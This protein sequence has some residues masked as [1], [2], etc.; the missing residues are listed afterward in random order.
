MKAYINNKTLSGTIAVP[1]SK[2]HTIRALIIATLAGGSSVIKNPL[3]SDD[4]RAALKAVELFG[5]KC[6]A[7][8]DEWIVEAPAGGLKT[9][10]DVVNVDN[11]GTTLYF[12]TSVASLLSDWVV[13]TGDKSIRKRPVTPL[14]DAL[15]Q[16]GV[17]AFETRIG[18]NSA[19]FVVK[20]PIKA[21]LVK[22][23]GSPSQ[24]ISSLL[25]SSPMCEG[26][27]R[28]ETDNPMEIPYLD[29]TID[30]MRRTGV[31]AEYDKKGYRWFEIKGKQSYKPFTR[32]IPG[33]WSSAAFPMIAGLTSGS[34]ITIE[35]LD[36]FDK[37]GDAIVAD[38]L[39]A[40]G[41]RIVKDQAGG[42][43]H[44]KG[45][46]ILHGAEMDM[47]SVPDAIPAMAVAGCAAD[48]VTVLKNVSGA[49][50]KETDRVSVMAEALSKMGAEITAERNTMTIYGGKKLR[51]AQVESFGDH[52]VAMAMTVA[53]LFAEG[54]TIVNDADCA[55][56]TFPKFY[57]KM[58]ALG[59]GIR[60]EQDSIA[61]E[62]SI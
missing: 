53:G 9:P 5:S 47:A 58:N 60:V 1:G 41:A 20:G 24:Y 43:L 13:F 16:L 48:G 42:K 51:G 6:A 49:R 34:E 36:F 28:I 31:E 11:S 56:I 27:M 35:N 57:E 61:E 12:M 59:A 38:Y 23:E 39:A 55:K 40:M 3:D 15:K 7:G 22:V 52:R 25:I 44:I 45:G 30:W 2:S 29:M 32:S 46:N 62:D 54:E 8:N 33:D 21:G 17:S 4:C 26:V 50:L 14:L 19:P 10:D 37:Q 18:S